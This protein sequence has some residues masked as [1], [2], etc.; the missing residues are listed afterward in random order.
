LNIVPCNITLTCVGN[1]V[2]CYGKI[3]LI[4][5]PITHSRKQRE[6]TVCSL[7][8]PPTHIRCACTWALHAKNTTYL[9]FCA[10]LFSSIYVTSS[11]LQSTIYFLHKSSSQNYNY[12][13]F[14]IFWDLNTL[15]NN[16][17]SLYLG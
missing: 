12:Y 8:Y 14:S 9:S 2:V 6:Y 5:D 10:M 4:V 7:S 13:V 3:G 17:S 11:V 15:W 1:I 16:K